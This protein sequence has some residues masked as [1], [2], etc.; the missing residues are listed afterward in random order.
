MASKGALLIP[1]ENVQTNVHG[2]DSISSNRYQYNKDPANAVKQYDR[3]RDRILID[4]DV[5]TAPRE[6]KKY[7]TS[8][9]DDRFMVGWQCAAMK[10]RYTVLGRTLA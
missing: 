5:D 9:R 4:A 10:A 8:L 6:D 1:T 7:G 3:L 2:M